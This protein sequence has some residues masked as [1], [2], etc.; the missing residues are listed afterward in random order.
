[1]DKIPKRKITVQNND[2]ILLYGLSYHYALRM[3]YYVLCDIICCISIY[4]II[5]NNTSLN[6]CQ[7]TSEASLVAQM[8]K[9]PP[10]MQE[11]RVRSL[12]QEDPL[13]KE[14][15]THD[16]TLAWKIPLTEEPYKIQ[17]MG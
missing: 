14:M 10:A 8:V 15:A 4:Y 17:S 12:G 6:A 2:W 16:S 5:Y 1:M 11:T 9:C 3:T 7:V 13:E